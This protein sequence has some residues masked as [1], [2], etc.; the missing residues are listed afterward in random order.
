MNRKTSNVL[1][2]RKIA[3]DL[4]PAPIFLWWEMGIGNVGNAASYNV[5][6]NGGKTHYIIFN[7]TF[8]IHYWSFGKIKSN[9]CIPF[10]AVRAFVF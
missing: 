6:K 10:V 3:Y 2:L 7:I 9:V 4:V 8:S 5:S 1:R